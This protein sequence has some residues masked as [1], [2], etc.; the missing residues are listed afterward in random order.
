MKTMKR[1]GAMA[2]QLLLA[3]V[4]LIAQENW[5]DTIQEVKVGV[6]CVLQTTTQLN[7]IIWQQIMQCTNL[8]Y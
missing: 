7:K 1:N 5:T 6:V 4:P 8:I 3:A 2:V